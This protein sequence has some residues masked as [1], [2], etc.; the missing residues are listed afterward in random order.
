MVPHNHHPAWYSREE[1][2]RADRLYHTA[3]RARARRAQCRH[4]RGTQP[5]ASYP[6]DHA[7]HGAGPPAH[8]RRHGRGLRDV[9][10]AGRYGVLG[11]FGLHAGDAGAH[12]HRVLRDLREAGKP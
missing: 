9:E 4:H 5:S 6:Y 2:Y 7:H 8:G 11:P 3:S 1:R 10:V 12:P